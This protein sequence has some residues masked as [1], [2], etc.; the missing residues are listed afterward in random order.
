MNVHENDAIY[1]LTDTCV[2]P[3]TLS[4]LLAMDD[5]HA[6]KGIRMDYG[7]IPG[8]DRLRRKIADL[9]VSAP[10]EQITTAHGCLEANALVLETLLKP[11][12]RVITYTPSYQQFSDLS[13]SLG[14]KVTAL[15]LYEEDGWQPHIDDLETAFGDPVRLVILNQPNNPTGTVFEPPYLQKLGELTERYHAWILADEVYRDPAIPSLSD[16]LPRCI[17]TGSLSKMYSLAGLRLGWIRADQKLIT[18][19]NSRRDYTIISTGPLID[20]LGLAA[21]SHQEEILDRSRSLIAANKEAVH[22]WLQNEP[23]AHVCMPAAGTVCFLRYD[24]GMPSAA[25]AEQMLKDTGVFF[26][27]GSC[28]DCE[29]HLR[30]GL[31]NDPQLTAQGLQKFSAWMDQHC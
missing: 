28:F 19:I 6:S 22:E 1:N 16:Q 21:L 24:L 2:H 27:P 20:S 15:P 31:T 14:C 26:V 18:H 7:V 11:G 10:I 25:L 3:L 29:H 8:D 13:R 4:E 5:M 17:S 23:R 12:D 30:L 9:Y